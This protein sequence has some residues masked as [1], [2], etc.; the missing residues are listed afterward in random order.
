MNILT[1]LWK[2]LILIA[3]YLIGSIPFGFIIGKIKG[4]DIREHGSKN[5][6]S[7]NV[8]RV[9]GKKYAIFTYVFD[10]IK[11]AVFVF[12][13]RYGIIPEDLCFLSPIVYGLVA[14]L[15]HTFPVYLGYKGGKAVATS[16][17]AILAYA[18]LLY[19]IAVTVFAVILITSKYVSLGS[20]I[21]TLIV[22]IGSFVYMFIGKDF[23]TGL[24]VDFY[25]PLVCFFMGFIIFFRHRGNIARLKHHS[26]SKINMK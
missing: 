21:A 19:V 26:E 5:I 7:T 24:P 8:G 9:L 10:T 25:F 3:A 17:G 11:G 6:G 13:F 22:F 14:A 4:I 12:L 23:I 15:G 2:I 1:W 18:P 20:L 16:S